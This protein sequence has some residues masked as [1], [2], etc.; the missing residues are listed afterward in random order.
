MAIGKDLASSLKSGDVVALFGEL[1]SGKTTFIRGICQFFSIPQW[2]KSP[3]FVIVREYPAP[4]PIYHIDLYRIT[5]DFAELDDYLNLDGIILI[6]WAEKV[7][8]HLPDQTIRIK[9]FITGVNKR[10]IEIDDPRD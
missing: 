7:E 1:G 10:E 3:S 5:D 9:L 4:I 2:V 6:E 8:D